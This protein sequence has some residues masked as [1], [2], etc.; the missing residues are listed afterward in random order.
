MILNLN[1]KINSI[2]DLEKN[3]ISKKNRFRLNTAQMREIKKDFSGSNVLII[4]AAGSIGSKFVKK[5]YLLNFRHLFLIDK[6]ENDLTD[7]NRFLVRKNNPKKINNTEFICTDLNILNLEKF[8]AENRITHYFNFAAVKHVRSEENY[9]SLKY[10]IETNSKNFINE[11]K[12]YSFKKFFSVSTDKSVNPESF[13]GFSKK[14]MEAKMSKFKKNNKKVFTSSARFANVSFSN[15]SILKLIIEKLGT[16]NNIGIP[17]NIKRYFITH[18]ESISLCLKSLL[19]ENDNHILLPN[20]KILK[21]QYSII[22]IL[23]KILKYFKINYSF[24]KKKNFIYIKKFNQKIFLINR[25]IVGQK[26]FEEISEESE[27]PKKIK[28]DKTVLKT[29]LKDTH[30]Y[31]YVIKKLN[32]SKNLSEL[33]SVIRTYQKKSNYK[34][35][36]IRL[37]RS[38]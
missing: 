9:H 20:E 36:K 17:L 28:G 35:N 25:N 3:I 10:M 21:R 12:S 31:K 7:L 4:G 14:L 29:P 18:E 24:S 2:E 11:K 6:N 23:I 38:I 26:N 33:K 37:S 5:I 13:L 16:D 19:K 22:E 34:K 15:G 1:N 8:I 27:N 30:N 32:Y